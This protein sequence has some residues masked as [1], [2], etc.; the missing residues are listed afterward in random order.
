MRRRLAVGIVCAAAALIA[1]ALLL[2]ARRRARPAVALPP[3]VP[4]FPAQRPREDPEVRS[5]LEAVDRLRKIRAASPRPVDPRDPEYAGVLER[6][7]AGAPVSLR[8][9]QEAVLDRAEDA[10]LRVELLN[11]VAAARGEE[12][13]AF[14]AALLGD[15]AE[16]PMVRVAS[17]YA[18]MSYRDAA[19][20]EVLRRA[21]EDPAFE[22]RYHVC[23]A[24]GE[25]GRPE[26]RDL[27]RGALARGQPGD[28][29][30]HAAAGLGGFAGQPEVRAEL[31]KLALEDPLPAVRQNALRSLCRSPEREVEAFLRSVVGR[32]ET[33]GDT[34]RVAEA[35][36]R[37]RARGP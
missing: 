15:P 12:S 25:N 23:V 5:T 28:V 10:A 8:Y 11:L 37:Q 1:A 19:T 2:E 31:R 22:G 3:R 18:I 13:R 36:L 33:D 35:L 26:G 7:R 14:L 9:L 24:L 4:T 16:A 21:F 20:F 6:V 30:A 17:L 32:P 34:R 27:L 29:R